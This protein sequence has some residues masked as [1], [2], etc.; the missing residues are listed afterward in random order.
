VPPER[1]K[2]GEL[3][4][5]AG[6]VGRADELGSLERILDELDRG[7]PGAIEMAGE[8]G[9]GKTRLLKE[10]AAR[11]E[12]RGHLVLFGTA[13]ELEHDLPF[14]VFIDALDEYVAG[15]EPKRLAVLDD[16]VQA[17]LAQVFPSLSALGGGHPV[18]LQSE[19]H[20]SHRAVRELLERLA[21][22]T[23]LVLVLDD[24]HWADSASVELLGALLRRPPTAAVLTALAVRPRRTPERFSAAL[25]RAHRDGMLTRIELG[26]LTFAEARDFLG[27][28]VEATEAAVLY[29]ES[30]GNP[31]YLQQLARAL[32]RPAP[33]VSGAELSLTIGVPSAVAASLAEELALLS[34]PARLVLEGASVA[35][36]PFEPELAAAAAATSEASAMDAIDR[37][38]QFDLVRT[39]DVPRR[40]RFRHALVRRAVYEATPAG[41]R[42]GAHERC[43]EALAARGATAT[44]R[45]YH[46]ERSAREGDVGAVA[47]LREA[48][49]AAAGLAPTSAARWF[50]AALRLLPD[51]ASS[52]ERVALLLAR[53]GSLAATGRFAESHADLLAC[54]EIA[55]RDAKAWRVRVTTACAAIEHLLGLQKEA[56]E[57]LSGALA[58]QEGAGSAEAVELMM[59]LTVDGFHA[60]DFEAMR[61]WADRAVAAATSLGDRPLLAAALAVR[62]WAGA[63]AGDGD[64]AQT[65]GDEATK[66][67]DE[68]SDDELARRLGALAH[69]ASADLFLDRFTAATRHG[70]RALQIGRVTGQGDLFPLVVVMLGGSLSVRG[71]PLEAGELLD[72]AVEA[73]RLAGNVQSL[74]WNLLNRAFAALVAGDLEV[75]LATAEE[76]FELEEG[77][78]PGPLSAIA[79]AVL[80]SALFETGQAERSVELLLTRAGGYELPLIAGGWRARFLELLTRALL[81]LGRRTDA[82]RA[83]A[84]A[85]ACADA[86]ALPSAAAMA[87]LAAAAL[88]LDAGEP[89]TAAERALAAAASL[90]GVS[91]LW[92]AARARELAGRALA[93]AGDREGAT[94]QLELAAAAFGSFGS[95]RYRDRAERELRKLGRHIHRRTRPSANGSGIESLTGR[96]LQ[97]ARLVVDRMTNPQIAGELFLS[98]KTVETHLRNIF[99]KMDVTTRTDLARAV[100]R[101]DRA[102]SARPR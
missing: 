2:R 42:L 96:E 78:E 14:S 22:P 64:R 88:A 61:G 47:I 68:L 45:A 95:F 91:A 75:A 63:V 76:S 57:H 101:A 20:R 18:A 56:H 10:L 87:S 15:L 53:A 69:L 30:G 74:A 59:E 29:E 6:L 86:V 26:P 44:A 31:F 50:G 39:T 85:Q 7:H 83:A 23:A 67:V 34:E 54:L 100:E 25:E 21:A 3:P 93:Q 82:E 12:A 51:V 92:D 32:D 52:E 16:A 46:V 37:L 40:F 38:L 4:T 49:E 66:L 72:G 58:D 94:V 65:H 70:E 81:S 1:A 33:T 90:E 48:G 9:I 71:R 79:A 19:R 27:D 55:T 35:G 84:S 60:G 5:V 17:E 36:D 28:A 102:A 8:P 73:A 77:M 13:S 89:A 98:E 62:A 41:W 80:G 43:A 11:A 24:V 99:H 97:V